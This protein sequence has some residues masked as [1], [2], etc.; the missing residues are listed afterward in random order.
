LSSM[1]KMMIIITMYAGRIGPLTLL[2][3]FSRRRALGK[4]EYVE[5]KVMIG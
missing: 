4:F 5:E 1:S 2:Y 3:A